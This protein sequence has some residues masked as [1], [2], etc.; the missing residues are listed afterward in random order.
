MFKNKALKWIFISII[1]LIALVV[2]V[3]VGFSIGEKIVFSEFYSQAEKEM[4]IPGLSE[5]YIPQGFD[6]VEEKD[7]YLACGYMKDKSPSRIYVIDSNGNADMVEL[8]KQN[9]DSYTGH[10]GGID[11]LGDFVYISCNTGCV[12]FSMT[13]I[14]DGDGTATVTGEIELYTS[15]SFCEIKDGLLYAGEF[16]YPESY[17]T[18][19]HFRLTTPAGDYNTSIMPV[20]RLDPE[21]GMLASEIPEKIY[22]IR[23][24]VQGVAFID[25]NTMVLSTS[26][27][28]S[29]SHLYVYDLD[30]AEGGETG[31]F[32]VEGNAVPLIFLDSASLASDITAPPMAEEI[33]VRNGRI[34]IMNESAS[35]KYIFGKFTTG[36]HVYSYPA[37]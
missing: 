34:Y 31:S 6:Y 8:K 12:I 19:E 3:L 1:G 18:P 29:K 20:Y 14:L 25:D 21:T 22:S 16:Y 11:Y 26:W 2:L 23:G 28:I 15:P 37:K 27:G 32:D 33:L 9:G 30:K 4:P 17:E 13:D 36:S 5:G 24:G 10:A 35:N 7:V